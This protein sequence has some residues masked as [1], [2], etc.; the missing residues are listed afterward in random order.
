MENKNELRFHWT[1]FE[2]GV[3]FD[4]RKKIQKKSIKVFCG[5]K[6]ISWNPFLKKSLNLMHR[7]KTELCKKDTEE[8]EEIKCDNQMHFEV[9]HGCAV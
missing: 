9:F 4:H 5:V 6:K 1:S 3:H 8:K 2:Q 7:K